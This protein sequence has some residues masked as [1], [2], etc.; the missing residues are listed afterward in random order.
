MRCFALARIRTAENQLLR[1]GP[2]AIVDGDVEQ[3][4]LTWRKVGHETR[5]DEGCVDPPIEGR[6]ALLHRIC[7]RPRFV[8]RSQQQESGTLRLV[9]H[10]ED[11]LRDRRPARI[12]RIVSRSSTIV[13][14]RDVEANG[15]NVVGLRF[16]RH[17]DEPLVAVG[18][19]MD[20]K[21]IAPS[22]RQIVEKGLLLASAYRLDKTDTADAGKGL[23]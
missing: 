23:R 11:T 18:E 17:D 7:R 8:Q 9:L 16:D 14:E 10:K 5:A 20:I 12:A 22:G 19:R 21:I 6:A 15:L 2:R 13:L 4:S 1:V 3:R